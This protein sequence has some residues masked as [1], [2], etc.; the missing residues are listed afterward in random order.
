[1]RVHWS[2]R[3]GAWRARSPRVHPRALSVCSAQH[4]TRSPVLPAAATA[5]PEAVIERTTAGSPEA[6]FLHALAAA[7]AER[8][9]RLGGSCPAPRLFLH[10]NHSQ[11]PSGY[12]LL[13]LQYGQHSVVGQQASSCC[14]SFRRSGEAEFEIVVT[15]L[16]SGAGS[17][18]NHPERVHA[19]TRTPGII[20]VG[21]LL[22]PAMVCG[23]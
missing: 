3:L 12:S 16:Q 15:E 6:A 17:A 21:V 20:F 18:P 9:G 2:A 8:P 1:M 5:L 19:S 4:P 23:P 10:S 14:L 22:P 11:C 13:L 7:H